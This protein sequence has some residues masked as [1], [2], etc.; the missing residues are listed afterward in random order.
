MS[1]TRHHSTPQNQLTGQIQSIAFR[2]LCVLYYSAGSYRLQPNSA[3][4]W[5]VGTLYGLF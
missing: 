4:Y 5:E 3:E 2:K 1:L